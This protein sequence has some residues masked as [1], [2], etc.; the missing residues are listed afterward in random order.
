MLARL[1]CRVEVAGSGRE[2]LDRLRSGTCDFVFIG[3][4]ITLTT[5][6]EALAIAR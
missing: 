1:G 5:M 4:P 2:A 6:R 3:K